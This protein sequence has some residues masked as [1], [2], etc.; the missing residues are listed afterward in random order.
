ML[1]NKGLHN[2]RMSAAWR[3]RHDAG[4]TAHGLPSFI[5]IDVED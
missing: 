3:D 1:Q 2:H 5:K 4:N